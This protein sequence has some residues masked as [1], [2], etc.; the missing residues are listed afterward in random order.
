[1]TPEERRDF[2]QQMRGLDDASLR[3]LVILEESAYR[4]EVV[5]IARD[6][7]ARR[8]LQPLSLE[9]F[10]RT[11]PAEWIAAVGFCYPC[12]SVTTAEP[13]RTFALHGLIGTLLLGRD[14]PC[15]TCGSVVSTTWFCVVLPVFRTR[16]RYRV[17][18]GQGGLITPAPYIGRR[19]K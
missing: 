5:D 15:A 6:E 18:Y 1:M 14:D 17:L 10:W 4:P 19:L 2:E 8:G 16:S 13:P 12:W 11:F 7:L 3:R 9:N